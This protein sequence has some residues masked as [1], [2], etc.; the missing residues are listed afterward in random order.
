MALASKKSTSSWLSVVGAVREGLAALARRAESC[1][2]FTLES[3]SIASARTTERL[4]CG[5]AT[6][7]KMPIIS[8]TANISIKVNPCWFFIKISLINLCIVYR[9]FGEYSITRR[10]RLSLKEG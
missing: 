6:E 4:Y 1:S 8:T 7:T 5:K 9:F 10:V 2:V 3:A